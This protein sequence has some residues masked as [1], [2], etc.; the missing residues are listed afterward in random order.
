MRGG[1]PSLSFCLS[2]PPSTAAAR[3]SRNCASCTIPIAKVCAFCL[4]LLSRNYAIII[5]ENKR[6][7]RW[8]RGFPRVCHLTR[9]S[10]VLPLLVCAFGW[11][12]KGMMCVRAAPQTKNF[13][14]N[15][16]K[17]LDKLIQMWYNDYRN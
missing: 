6:G 13:L 9:S 4:L 17:T 1:N 5:I 16:K 10:R 14:R 8:L 2:V 11:V 15:F 3:I 12:G 7:V